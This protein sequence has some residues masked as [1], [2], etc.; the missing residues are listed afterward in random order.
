MINYFKFILII[1]FII[2]FAYILI[3]C[4]NK[5]TNIIGGFQNKS[6][7]NHY[8][9]NDTNKTYLYND[10]NKTY[11]YHGSNTKINMTYLIPKYSKLFN[12]DSGIVKMP[13]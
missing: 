12:N 7:S 9:Y 4:R 8:L 3:Y 11:L 6:K 5:S 2:I 10:T 13:L 1:I